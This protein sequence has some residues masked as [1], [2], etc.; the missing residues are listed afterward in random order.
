MSIGVDAKGGV[1]NPRN[2]ESAK[3]LGSLV[4]KTLIKRE[5]RA[6]KEVKYVNTPTTSKV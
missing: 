4:A 1:K 2:L 5:K 3:I 6:K